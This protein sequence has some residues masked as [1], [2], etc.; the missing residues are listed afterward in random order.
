MPVFPEAN[1]G[2]VARN[3]PSETAGKATHLEREQSIQH[4][5]SCE[6]LHDRAEVPL[7]AISHKNVEP[8]HKFMCQLPRCHAAG[9]RRTHHI[10]PKPWELTGEDEDDR[11]RKYFS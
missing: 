2:R 1:E 5:H 10:G 9:W 4:L 11:A 7:R 3:K 6:H 8:M